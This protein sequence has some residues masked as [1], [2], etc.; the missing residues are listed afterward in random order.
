MYENRGVNI[1]VDHEAIIDLKSDTKIIHL[2]SV[3]HDVP[4]YHFNLIDFAHVLTKGKGSRILTGMTK[5][6]IQL[7]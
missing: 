4:R 7:L 3:T 1:V 2:D 6:Q 5:I